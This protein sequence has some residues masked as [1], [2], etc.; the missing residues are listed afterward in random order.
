MSKAD[1]A[2]NRNRRKCEHLHLQGCQQMLGES[3]K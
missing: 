1:R 2:W 3:A